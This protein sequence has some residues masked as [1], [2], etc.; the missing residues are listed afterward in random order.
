MRLYI[1]NLTL[2]TGRIYDMI[3]SAEKNTATGGSV[4]EYEECKDNG[5][6]A[7]GNTG[8]T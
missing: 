3:Y 2:K 4:Y 8:G 6:A 1:N 5:A 7:Q